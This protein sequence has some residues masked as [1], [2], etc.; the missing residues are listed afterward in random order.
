VPERK[1]GEKFFPKYAF[2]LGKAYVTFY[3]TGAKAIYSNF[4]SARPLQAELD[5]KYNGS[6][7]AAIDDKFLN[8]GQFQLLTR[9]W[10]DIK[11]VP[12]FA[13]LFAIC[14]EFTPLVVVAVTSIVPYVCRIPK[15]IESDRKTLESRRGI[16]FRNLTSDLPKNGQSVKDLSRM[17]VLHVSWSLGLSS[18]V[19]DYL[20]G[21][22]PG[23]PTTLLRNKVDRRVKYLEMDD[24]LI[25]RDG[26]VDGMSQL[27]LEIACVERGIDV[28]GRDETQLKSSLEAWLNARDVT[29]IETLLLT[30][31]TILLHH[32]K[33]IIFHLTNKAS[34]ALRVGITSTSKG[35]ILSVYFDGRSL[36]FSLNRSMYS[37]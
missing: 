21:K 28:V 24:L 26:G 12:L 16:S 19:W 34:Q 14:G 13:L 1:E 15:Q 35:M 8:R 5:N 20:G 11:R 3:K 37:I 23:L 22:L 10:F 31:Y 18:S 2:A 36:G 4:Q 17:Q 25:K 7:R 29:S 9:S 32:V 30:R 33:R 27:E 6:L